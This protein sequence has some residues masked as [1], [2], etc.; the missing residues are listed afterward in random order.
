MRTEDQTAVIDFLSS[1]ATHGGEPVER[2]DTHASI[3]FLAGERAYKLKRAVRFDYL[4]FSTAERRRR[5]CDAELV[6][7]RRL[8]PTLYRG[9]V[10][11]TR[12]EDG[13]Y[14]LGGP[15]PP[16]DWLVEMNRFPQ[17]G[18]LDRLASIGHLELSWMPALA[19]AIATFH[20]TAEHRSD[21]GG[22]SGMAWVIDGN[23][24][25]FAEFGAAC[26]DASAVN[27][28][29]AESR[30]TLDRHATLLDERRSSG[31]VR[32]CHG[33]LH[34]RNI[35]L[36]DG[37]PTMFDG[38]EF[39]DEIS[40]T[41]VLYD[42]AFLLMDLWQRGLHRHA[43]AVWNRYLATTGDLGG[44]PLMPLFLSCRAAVRAKT[45]ATAAPLQQDGQRQGEIYDLARRHLA[46]AEQL[47]HPSP[48]SLIA[49]GGFS[50]TGK[51]T[52][53]L[54]LAPH[55]GPPPGAVV[56]RSDEIRKALCGVSRL[57]PLGP[58]GYSPRVSERV[59][60]ALSERAAQ[61]VRSGHSAIVDAVYSRQIDRTTIERVAA[62]RS[63]PFVG[64]WLEAAE[65]LLMA[66]AEQRRNDPSDADAQVVRRQCQQNT[67][68]IDWFR[69]DASM[70]P[71]SV[72][73]AAENHLRVAH[74][75][76]GNHPDK[77]VFR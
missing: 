56:L 39:N 51:S 11:I 15:G 43:N 27:R 22:R 5:M 61:V 45:N 46:M 48:P 1:P 64:L 41:D 71:A 70:A 38:V 76:G 13:S 33:D 14:A 67:G 65:S 25:G 23:A 34:L 53:A 20:M 66:R 35:V 57:A 6:L 74:T 49:V 19:T 12:R 42:L 60:A 58:E 21:H 32:Q 8:A 4:D 77:Y 18:L 29:V 47:L 3:V 50:G 69:I 7:N 10:A 2:I 37:K 24:S 28:L 59:Y 26:L 54:G 73:R 75:S 63:V 55:L 40:C 17:E 52:L 44:L 16:V 72:R 9:V 36:L 68:P 30:S 31:C 62:E